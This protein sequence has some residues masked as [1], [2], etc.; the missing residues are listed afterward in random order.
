MPSGLIE[1]QHSV[2]ARPDL[3]SD[4][5]KVQVHG[6]GIAMGQ[7]EPSALAFLWA[8]GTENIGRS[9]ALIGWRRRP[10][11]ASGPAP[12]DLIFLSDT[13]FVSEPYFYVL[14]REVG[15]TRDLIQ[16]R[17]ETFLKSSMAPSA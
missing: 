12:R 15:F 3:R 10:R 14:W 8:D 16:A 11:P 5:S 9:R 13:S 4:F 6:L 7:D 1:D 17:G 2:C